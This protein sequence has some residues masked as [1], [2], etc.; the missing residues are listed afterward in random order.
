MSNEGEII[1]LIRTLGSE[2]D[3]ETQKHALDALVKI[4]K[5][6]VIP[7]IKALGNRDC[8]VRERAAVAL[9]K[10]KDRKTIFKANYNLSHN[11]PSATMF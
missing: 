11:S 6:V 2:H 8:I 10:I 9:G 5:P 4:N 1:E 7:L 3:H